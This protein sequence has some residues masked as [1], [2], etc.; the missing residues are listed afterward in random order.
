MSTAIRLGGEFQ[1]RELSLDETKQISGG[2]AAL[3]AAA[4]IAAVAA[5]AN[6]M[7]TFGEKVGKALYHAIN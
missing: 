2:N 6:G 4:G 7:E 3:V 1:V 5:M